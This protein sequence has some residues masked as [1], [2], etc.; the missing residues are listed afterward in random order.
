MPEERSAP[1]PGKRAYH[2]PARQRHAEETRQRILAASRALL[3]QRGYAGT[4]LEAIAEEAGVSAK[5]VVATFGS[6]RGI[7]AE[8]V[9][10]PAFGGRYQEVLAHLRAEPDPSRRVAL[11]AQLTRQVYEALTPEFELLRGA[12][13]VAPELAEVAH[14]VE[15]RRWHLQERFVEFL[16][17]QGVLHADRSHADATD[18]VWALTSFDLYR[19]LVRERGWTALRYEAWL[20]QA[21]MQRLF[22]SPGDRSV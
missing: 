4:T 10:P 15:Q 8:L 6:K 3:Q 17:E 12:G 1:D 11:V 5:T 9:S 14:T 20:T 18:E 21:L 22:L 13:A 19:L 16:S 7:L 2:S